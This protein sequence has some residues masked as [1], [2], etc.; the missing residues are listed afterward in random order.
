MPAPLPLR[1]TA[2]LLATLALG[3]CAEGGVAGVLRSAGAGGTPDE[4]MVLPTKPL[5]MP[6][7]MAALPAPTPGASNR[8]DY[9]PDV[10]AVASLTGKETAAAGTASAGALIARAGPVAPNIRADLAADDAVFREENRG[11]LI[12][13]LLFQ[14]NEDKLT[15]EGVMLDAPTAFEQLRA[16]GIAVPPAPPVVLQAE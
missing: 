9:H 13:R 6:A 7:D 3:G 15:Y 5:E 11:Q 10:E 8:V 2:L 4:F 12:P 1:L 16:R 14:G